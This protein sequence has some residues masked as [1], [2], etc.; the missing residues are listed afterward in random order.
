MR[1]SASLNIVAPVNRHLKPPGAAR[2]IASAVILGPRPAVIAAFAKAGAADER[3]QRQVMT[4]RAVGHNHP[5][6]HRSRLPVL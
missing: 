6:G 2:A 3:N 5:E 4:P 1:A